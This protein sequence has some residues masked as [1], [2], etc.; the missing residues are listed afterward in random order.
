MYSVSLRTT[1]ERPSAH[2][3]AGV[4]PTYRDTPRDLPLTRDAPAT[5]ATSSR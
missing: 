5:F 4:L 3:L 1:D 2:R